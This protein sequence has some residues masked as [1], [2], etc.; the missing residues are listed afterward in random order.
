[1]KK[2]KLKKGGAPLFGGSGAAALML[3]RF[4]MSPPAAPA[5]KQL[6]KPLMLHDNDSEPDDSE[7]D[8]LTDASL[9]TPSPSSPLLRF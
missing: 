8:G 1:M 9:I 4:D 7:P 6:G 2:Q 5:A 3:V